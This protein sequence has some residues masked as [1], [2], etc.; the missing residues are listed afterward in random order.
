MLPEAALDGGCVA[1]SL[2]RDLNDAG[3]E[4]LEDS[5]R[6]AGQVPCEQRAS[7]VTASQATSGRP[8]LRLPGR[9]LRHGIRFDRERGFQEDLRGSPK[10]L[11]CF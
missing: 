2:Q 9:I 1:R 3:S 10:V 5:L 7:A 8:I 11:R 4:V 6:S